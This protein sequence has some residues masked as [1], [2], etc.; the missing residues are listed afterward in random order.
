MS[1]CRWS[2]DDF[3]CDLYCYE[4]VR[5]GWTT[6][7]SGRR[8]V[9]DIKPAPNF[10]CPGYADLPKDEQMAIAER[11][12]AQHKEHMASVEACAL[13][14]IDLPHAGETFNDPTL[15]AFRERLIYLRSVGYNFPDYV[16]EVVDEEI[17]DASND[18]S[19]SSTAPSSDERQHAI[20][21]AAE[22]P[23]EI[24]D[25]ADRQPLADKR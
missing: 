15:A 1:Y 25:D 2:S 23:A 20:Q 24:A 17:A 19:L 12:A 4:D 18:G 10:Y 6:H 8:H 22:F 21:Q 5:G 14:D 3:R 11:W 16:L 7:V 13:V 9:G